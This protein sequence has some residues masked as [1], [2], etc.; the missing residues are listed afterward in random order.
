VR[1]SAYGLTD[2]SKE[3]MHNQTVALSLDPN[4]DGPERDLKQLVEKVTASGSTASPAAFQLPAK[5]LS[6]SYLM[7]VRHPFLRGDGSGHAR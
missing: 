6:I 5:S 3:T 1:A 4:L 7:T 2:K